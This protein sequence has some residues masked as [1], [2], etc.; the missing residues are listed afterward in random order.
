M[1][2]Y[3]S[4]LEQ[5]GFIHLIDYTSPS[6]QDMARLFAH[7]QKYYFAEVG[8]LSSLPMFCSISCRLEQHWLL[9]VTKNSATK[10]DPIWYAFL[11]QPRALVKRIENAPASVLLESLAEWQ[12][13]ISIDL[14]VK[15]I[16]D[17]TVEAYFESQRQ[18]RM[19]KRKLLIR[20]SIT[21]GLI[22][23]LYFL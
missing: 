3:T 15:I 12:Q 5:L 18:Q 22:E 19:Q 11:R 1:N 8:Q 14:K 9:A 17:I 6:I 7:P 21:W 13:Q 20:K 4:E 2:R 23:T 16:S 10:L